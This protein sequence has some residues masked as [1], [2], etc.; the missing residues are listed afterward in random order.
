MQMRKERE[1]SDLGANKLEVT[2]LPIQSLFFHLSF[3]KVLNP[4][5]GEMTQS[6]KCLLAMRA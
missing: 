5:D 3:K 2:A 1:R 4:G 6:L